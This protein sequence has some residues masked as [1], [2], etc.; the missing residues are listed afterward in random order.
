MICLEVGVE[1]L[2]GRIDYSDYY[3]EATAFKTERSIVL[4]TYV[5][6]EYGNERDRGGFLNFLCR[7]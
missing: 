4:I 1:E 6:E 5:R 2:T 3:Y 7:H